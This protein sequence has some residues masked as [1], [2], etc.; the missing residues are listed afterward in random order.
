MRPTTGC[1]GSATRRLVTRKARHRWRTIRVQQ[2]GEKTVYDMYPEDW[3]PAMHQPENPRSYEA[4]QASL[5]LR[6][7]GGQRPDDN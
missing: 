6:D 3:G 1:A 4:I 2:Q 7:H 5:D